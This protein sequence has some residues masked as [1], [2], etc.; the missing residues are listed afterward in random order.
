MAQAIAEVTEGTGDD[1]EKEDDEKDKE[2]DKHKEP[3]DDKLAM[4]LDPIRSM[5]E[6][7]CL[8]TFHLDHNP[9]LTNIE[10]S[11]RKLCLC[12]KT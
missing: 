11:Y 1:K 6:K 8:F 12:S 10:C 2:Q 7:V 9:K 5:L 4:S 3:L